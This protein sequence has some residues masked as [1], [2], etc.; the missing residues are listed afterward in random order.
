MLTVKQ[1]IEKAS[2]TTPDIT[3]PTGGGL[4]NAQQV[5]EFFRVAIEAAPLLKQ[6]RSEFIGSPKAEVPRNALTAPAPR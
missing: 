5:K 4:L 3:A 1:W 2:W 6:V